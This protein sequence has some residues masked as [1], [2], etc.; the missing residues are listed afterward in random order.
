MFMVNQVWLF[1][2]RKDFSWLILK[3]K[4]FLIKGIKA[5]IKRQHLCV[6]EDAISELTESVSCA[7][8]ELSQMVPSFISSITNFLS[9]EILLHSVQML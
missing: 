6:K 1:L 5:C 2:Y 7:E 4:F 3:K 9:A 8:Q